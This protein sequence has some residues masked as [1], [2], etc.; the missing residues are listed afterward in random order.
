MGATLDALHRLQEV[1]MQI[2]EL[3]KGIDRKVRAVKQQESRIAEIDA[4]IKQQ[5]DS[6][7][8]GQMEA[9][10]LDLDVKTREAEI[11]KLRSALQLA[12][13]N[14][15]YSAILTQLN[16]FK[17]DSSKVEDR[18]LALM[19]DLD[20]KRAEIDALGQQRQAEEARLAELQGAVKEVEARSKTRLDALI[21]ERQEAAAAVPPS[22]LEFFERVSRKNDG[23]AMAR[24]IRTNPKRAEF[25][26]DGCNMSITIEQVNAILSRDEAITCNICGR[27]LY[28]DP[29]V[30]PGIRK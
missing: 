21:A 19:G 8:M 2:A 6:L 9:D 16:T 20:K 10:R 13:T 3:R 27:I 24:I 1:E 25:A 22:A 14:K 4:K 30:A 23:E 17:A 15:E 12:K 11:A 29:A 18:V 28:I 26:C 7:R 5:R